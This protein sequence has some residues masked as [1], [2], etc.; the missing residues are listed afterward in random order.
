ML[1]HLTLLYVYITIN[2]AVLLRQGSEVRSMYRKMPS[3][4]REMVEEILKEFPALKPGTKC[5]YCKKPLSPR[6]VE[7]KRIFCSN[8]CIGETYLRICT[9][10]GD[11]EAIRRNLK[12]LELI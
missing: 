1:A 7:K 9:E 6:E 2:F 3:M 10:E 11:K 8:H 12:R 5:P 4:Y